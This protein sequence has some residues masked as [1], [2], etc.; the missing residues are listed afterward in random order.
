MV[1]VDR[2]VHGVHPPRM[3]VLS[4]AGLRPCALVRAVVVRSV[5]CGHHPSGSPSHIGVTYRR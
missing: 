2:R 4:R 5:C 3:L 1:A